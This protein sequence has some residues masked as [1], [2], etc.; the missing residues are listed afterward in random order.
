[1]NKDMKDNMENQEEYTFVRETIK[2]KPPLLIR[3]F[4]KAAQILGLGIV[5]GL[6]VCFVLFVFGKDIRGIF[7]DKNGV[8]EE[9]TTLSENV[10]DTTLTGET[11][12]GEPVISVEESISSM[13][14]DVT[15]VVYEKE[16][17]TEKST[18]S[19]SDDKEINTTEEN[20]STME[21]TSSENDGETAAEAESETQKRKI[22]KKKHFTGVVVSKDKYVYICIA[23]DKI[24]DG[25]SVYVSLSGGE[26]TEA[27]IH[28][29]DTINN[30]AVLKVKSDNTDSVAAADIVS[31]DEL[32]SGHKLIYVGN[33]YGAG[34]LFY[35]GTLAGT[36]EGHGNYD[37]FYRCVITDMNNGD[38]QDGFLFDDKGKLVA[39]ISTM[40]G[41]TIHGKN[42]TGICMEDMLHVVK[43]IVYNTTINHI[44]IKG[45]TVTD[46]MREL[47]GEDMPDGMYVT[48]VARDSTSY[49]SG[50]MVGDIIT[51]AGI[52]KVKSLKDIQDALKIVKSDDAVTI[53][54]KRKIGTGYNEFTIKVPVEAY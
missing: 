31:M 12:D 42:V 6:G 50:I 54:L 37:T 1:M 46:D 41:N 48:D 18:V 25:D 24:K 13:M 53:V 17:E 2:E 19:I 30:I 16:E 49:K 38:I 32:G 45:D 47:T 43:S 35:S 3:V 14:A 5:F 39:M 20:E 28:G 51:S 33:P 4:I 22:E 34:R 36:D 15:V 52:K 40:E 29:Y 10:S 27:E 8:G 44:G 21:T 26:Q 7:G 23:Y 9:E 11:T